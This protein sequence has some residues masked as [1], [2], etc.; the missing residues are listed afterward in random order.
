M[1]V[2]I[3][4]INEVLNVLNELPKNI[5]RNTIISSGKKALRPAQKEAK[6]F[7]R[8][9]A[10]TFSNERGFSKLRY[11]A[12]N[13]RIVTSKNRRFPG[14]N[15]YVKGNDLPV[16]DRFWSISG[17]AALLAFGSEARAGRGIFRGFENYIQEGYKRTK[18][19][20]RKLFFSG[21]RKELNKA[22]QRVVIR[23]GKRY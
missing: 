22:V 23:Y 4:G 2:K 19:E 3:E 20:V 8:S 11:I 18:S 10:K 12:K 1:S 9:Q 14:V 7:L 21:I 16:G 17:Y 5:G 6:S 13:I 15:M